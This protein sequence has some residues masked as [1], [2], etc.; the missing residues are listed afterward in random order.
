MFKSLHPYTLVYAAVQQENI[1]MLTNKQTEIH[2]AAKEF[3]QT[4][5]VCKKASPGLSFAEQVR[6]GGE[7]STD[8]A[9]DARVGD[10]GSPLETVAPPCALCGSSH[11]LAVRGAHIDSLSPIAAAY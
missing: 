1:K 6:D 4:H 5:L 9:Q 7:L 8:G 3:K 11:P 10:S 2:S